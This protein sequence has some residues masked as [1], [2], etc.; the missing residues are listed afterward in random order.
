MELSPKR[1]YRAFDNSTAVGLDAS[2]DFV[3]LITGYVPIDS[4]ATQFDFQTV[5]LQAQTMKH[6]QIGANKR[7]LAADVP[8]NGIFLLYIPYQTSL[9]ALLY[10]GITGYSFFSIADKK[11]VVNGVQYKVYAQPVAEQTSIYAK[12]VGK[13]PG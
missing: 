10:N 5:D 11:A 1:Q 3:D 9:G 4:S 13:I 12:L 7:F 6:I 2:A 8:V